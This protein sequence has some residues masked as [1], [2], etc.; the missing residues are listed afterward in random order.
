MMTSYYVSAL[1]HITLFVELLYQLAKEAP[2]MDL[3]KTPLLTPLNMLN[4]I[5]F[6][7]VSSVV[8]QRLLFS[9]LCSSIPFESYVATGHIVANLI[10]TVKHSALRLLIAWDEGAAY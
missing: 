7:L 4:I 8:Y 5:R 3:S 6:L 9:C 2:T 1:S 10:S